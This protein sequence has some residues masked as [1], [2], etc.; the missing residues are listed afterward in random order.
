LLLTLPAL[1]APKLYYFSAIFALC[2]CW[3][4]GLIFVFGFYLIKESTIEHS[5]KFYS[6]FLF[7]LLGVWIAFECIQLFGLRYNIWQN[8]ECL[9]FPLAAFISGCISLMFSKKTILLQFKNRS[10]EL[11]INRSTSL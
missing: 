10:N 8:A 9:L 11:E 5:I 4:A 3:V 7:V 1:F 2:V 6:L